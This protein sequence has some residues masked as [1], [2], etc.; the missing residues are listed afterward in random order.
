M[1]KCSKQRGAMM[2]RIGAMLNNSLHLPG[3]GVG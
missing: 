3:V 1:S 2:Q